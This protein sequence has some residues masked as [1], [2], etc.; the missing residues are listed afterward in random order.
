MARGSLGSFKIHALLPP[1]QHTSDVCI[2]KNDKKALEESFII[3][4][5]IN[6]FFWTLHSLPFTRLIN[7]VSTPTG[8]L[9]SR[10]PPPRRGFLSLCM[11]ICLFVS[12]PLSAVFLSTLS[13]SLYLS[14]SIY[15]L[16]YI[17]SCSQSGTNGEA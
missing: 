9:T 15:L 5:L 1:T 14:L 8:S 2:I 13:L 6:F 17:V 12:L 7:C 3:I 4:L 10:L 16:S 11:P